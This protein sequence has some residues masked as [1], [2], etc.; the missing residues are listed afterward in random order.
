MRTCSTRWVSIV[1]TAEYDDLFRD[2][3]LDGP[4]DKKVDFFYIDRDVGSATIAQGYEGTKGPDTDA[5]ANKAA[6]LNTA[7]SWLLDSDLSKIREPAI[8]AAA[9]QL[10]DSLESGAVHT[11]H[12]YFIHN[13]RDTE[14]VDHELDTV[15]QSL[16]KDLDQ[17]ANRVGNPISCSVQQVSFS[18]VVSLYE[19]RHSFIRVTDDIELD[20]VTTPQPIAGQLWSAVSTTLSASQLVDLVRKYGVAIYSA[21]IRDY[22]GVRL[23]ARNINLQIAR[24]ATENPDNFWVFNNGVTFI[25]R[26]IKINDSNLQCGGLAVINGAQTLGTLTEVAEG[27]D[28]DKV[29]VPARIIESSD[30]TLIEQI[31]RFNNTQNPIKPWELRVLDPVQTRLQSEFKE[32]FGINY[33]FRRGATRRAADDL[34]VEKLGPWLNSF[35][36]DPNTS[37]R[38]SPELF[39]NDV[40]YRSLF[41]DASDSRNLLFVYRLGEAI[42]A[43]KDEY[44]RAVDAETASATES[45]LYGFFRYGAFTHIAL[46]L[47]GELLAEVF[48]GGPGVK[49]RF[50]LSEDLEKDRDKAIESLMRVVK[51]ALTP[52]P[53]ELGED[54]AYGRMRTIAGQTKL[55][56]R[57]KVTVGQMR[58]VDESVVGRL[59]EGIETL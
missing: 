3:V 39:D 16:R 31:I 35:Y 54:D 13:C 12:V 2:N 56:D 6:D 50:A 24:S 20:P 53:S 36:G 49:N 14:N 59:Q 8:K 42:A 26:K 52:I 17:W 21:N 51:F 29:V 15:E 43:T 32:R 41:S 4:D 40:K 48:G 18:A 37:H 25:T 38:N 1:G 57:V 27:Q 5:P 11:L 58:G 22:L 28:L 46:Y 30:Q 23:Y 34:L 55:A 45:T 33:Q 44:R 19:A 10:R 7:V 47:C 9:E